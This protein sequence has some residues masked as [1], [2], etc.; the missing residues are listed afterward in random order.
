MG[1]EE[2]E[3]LIR[4][5]EEMEAHY[6]RLYKGFSS[7]L[8]PALTEIVFQYWPEMAANRNKYKPLLLDIGK[9][10]VGEIWEDY[11]NCYS[12][13]V[14]DGPMADLNPVE[15]LE[16][17][18]KGFKEHCNKLKNMVPE[19]NQEYLEEICRED[20]E[21]E[22][23]ILLFKLDIHKTMKG[24]FVEFYIDDIMEFESHILRYFDRGL[25]LTCT[26]MYVDEV[27]SLD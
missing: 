12:L 16:E 24:V 6:N 9:K 13:N 23:K 10:Y 7:K 20:Y 5:K 11:N 3:N 25:Y 19:Q 27:F 14:K 18:K 1:L 17:F 15:T 22:K 8:P 26:L 21:T 2:F 4:R